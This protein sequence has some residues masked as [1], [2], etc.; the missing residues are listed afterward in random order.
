MRD[1]LPALE[2]IVQM[3]FWIGNGVAHGKY[4]TISI[5]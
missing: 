5:L 3:L 2:I 1:S 4:L